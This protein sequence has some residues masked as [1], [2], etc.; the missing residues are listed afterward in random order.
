MTMAQI[1][2][3]EYHRLVKKIGFLE[4]ENATL[5][6]VVEKFTST[7]NAMVPCPLHTDDPMVRC[8]LGLPG[9]CGVHC[10]VSAHH[11]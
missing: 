5:K 8:R 9:Y 10:K 3:S 7:N 4:G 1:D 11:Q 6:S 2:L